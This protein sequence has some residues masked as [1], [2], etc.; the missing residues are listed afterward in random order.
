MIPWISS[1]ELEGLRDMYFVITISLSDKEQEK[2]VYEAEVLPKKKLH[3]P[4]NFFP[5]YIGSYLEEN[6][7][8]NEYDFKL[9]H[10]FLPFESLRKIYNDKIYK[11]PELFDQMVKCFAFLQ[12]MSIGPF[13]LDLRSFQ[14]KTF[15]AERIYF[16]NYGDD[17]KVI[18]KYKQNGQPAYLAPEIEKCLID[19]NLEFNPFKANT[20]SFALT[21]IADNLKKAPENDEI[22]KLLTK[23][24]KK[25]CRFF[26]TN[27]SLEFIS[28]LRECLAVHPKER[29]DFIDLYCK[30]Y[31]ISKTEDIQK[32]FLLDGLEDIKVAHV[33]E[34]PMFVRNI[35]IIFFPMQKL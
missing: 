21:I 22:E 12:T 28:T 14:K 8:S 11:M 7:S 9:H 18:E 3:T 35:S 25:Y 10:V 31:N 33:W 24:Q 5:K 15:P 34:I 1:K 20:Y 16:R 26:K 23:F 30:R 29:P 6:L 19:S 2:E 13:F 4:N 32:L 17:R 27:D